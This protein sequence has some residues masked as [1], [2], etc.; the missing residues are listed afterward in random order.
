MKINNIDSQIAKISGGNIEYCL[1][2]KGPTVLISHGTLGGY[3]QGFAISQ[4]FNNDIF[5][6]LT[7]SRAGYLNS[8]SS[9]GRT[10]EEQ[11]QSYKELL[12]KEGISSIAILGTSGGAPAALRFAQ[13]YPERC[14]ALILMSSI[15]K[16]PQ[17]P[18][19]F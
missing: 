17:L 2:G 9:T 1:V 14:W 5:S 3:D 6:F 10:P 4:L 18:P 12:D 19:F 7:V 13:N 8:S 11:A 15:T 16:A